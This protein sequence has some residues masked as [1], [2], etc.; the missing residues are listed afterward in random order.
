MPGPGAVVEESAARLALA[1]VLESSAFANV[2]RLKRFLRFISEQTLAGHGDQLKEFLIAIDVF[3]KP[4]SFD[5]RNDPIVRV[6]ARRLRAKLAQYYETEGREDAVLID[7]PKGSYVPA[8]HLSAKSPQP[9]TMYSH[10]PSK[11]TIA[12]LPFADLTPLGDHDHFCCG[13]RDEILYAVVNS[14]FLRTIPWTRPLQRVDRLGPVLQTAEELD[15]ATLIDGSVRKSGDHLRIT[16][17][18]IDAVRGE[19][20]WSQ[21][22]DAREEN[23]FAV[24]EE[25]A[26]A[27][28]DVLR[29][30]FSGEPTA[31]RARRSSEKVAAHNLY[32][33]GRHCLSQRSEASLRRAVDYFEL[34]IQEDPKFALA[35]SGFADALALLANYGYV[36][37]GETWSRAAAE[38]TSAVLQDEGLAEAHTSLAHVNATHHWDWAGA[39]AEFQK[40]IQLN[41][42]YAAARHWFGIACL[43][44]QGRLDEAIQQ[45]EI[46]LELDP[47]SQIVSR[48]LAVLYFFRRNYSAAKDQAQLTIDQEPYFY[49]A[50]WIM[51]LVKEQEGEFEEALA[52]FRRALDLVPQNPRMMSA[53]GRCLALAGQTGE[54]RNVL[55]ALD[56]LGAERYVSP[57]DPA[58]IQLALEDHD[59]AFQRLNKLLEYRCFDLIHLPVDPRFDAQRKNPR[60][61]SLIRKLGLEQPVTAAR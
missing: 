3:E 51:G 9:R 30:N 52:C 31:G 6:Q 28:V 35:H 57:L 5:P 32:L 58:L 23:A 42:H 19:Y 59:H 48:D 25:I 44:P 34:A 27:V 50:Y 61:T 24:Q 37:P 2:D 21:M 39:E 11:N 16:V 4:P 22:F 54:A 38:A 33:K 20:V 17:Q 60:F 29:G 47:V 18:R 13:V 55:K 56:R 45:M 43:A 10:L 8:F 36:S 7:L 41:P 49:G 15:I 53:L 26:H 40:A 46:A 14:A 1:R 12:V